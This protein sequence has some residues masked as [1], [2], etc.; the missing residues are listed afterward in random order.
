MF[1]ESKWLDRL[2]TRNAEIDGINMV[3]NIDG[4][5]TDITTYRQIELE[6][7]FINSD[8]VHVK[9]AQLIDK[10]VTQDKNPELEV[11]LVAYEDHEKSHHY[12]NVWV[13]D[14]RKTL[15]EK[16]FGKYGKDFDIDT[17]FVCTSRQDYNQMVNDWLTGKISNFDLNNI[18]R[19]IST[20]L[21]KSFWG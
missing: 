19:P 12:D 3:G 7:K 17:D 4:R 9:T 16:Y 15:Q 20:E 21:A 10:H 2:V 13:V 11:H 8:M 5:I 6:A 14:L 18:R 1:N